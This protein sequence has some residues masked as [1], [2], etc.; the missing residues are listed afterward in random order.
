M[1]ENAVEL[2]QA[3]IP[4]HDL[5]RPAG[6]VIDAD[7]RAE[8]PGKFGFETAGVSV[9]GLLTC[10]SRRAIYRRIRP[11]YEHFGGTHGQPA[12]DHLGGKAFLL[13]LRRAEQRARVP[14]FQFAV[15]EAQA[16][17]GSSSS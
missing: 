14:H 1:P 12:L 3:R 13:C 11:P 4:D 8:A 6:A 5:P 10:H 15:F 17:C 7:R 2:I 9:F 16:Q